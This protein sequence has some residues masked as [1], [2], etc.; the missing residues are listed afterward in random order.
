MEGTHLVRSV[1]AER[2]DGENRPQRRLLC[3]SHIGKSLIP[4]IPLERLPDGICLSPIR[5]SVSPR[6]FT[7]LMKPVVARLRRSDVRLIIYLEDILFMNHS[8]PTQLQWVIST[9]I[10]LLE[11]LGFVTNLEK[12]QLNATQ[13]LEFL[14]F[15]VNTLNM[16]LVFP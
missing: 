10:H 3:G 6:I 14:G 12:S 8:T 15:L 13:T 2:L 1:T 11:N 9:A 5:S 4:A 7:K 16:T